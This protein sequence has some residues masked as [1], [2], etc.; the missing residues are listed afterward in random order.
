MQKNVGTIDRAL[1]IIVGLA[2]VGTGVYFNSWWGAIGLIPLATGLSCRCPA[3][4]PLKVST[5]RS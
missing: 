3:Y 1:R 2:V 4:V 5:R